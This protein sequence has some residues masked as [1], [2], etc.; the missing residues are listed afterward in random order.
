[1]HLKE[2]NNS[3]LLTVKEVASMCGVSPSHIYRLT[4]RGAIPKPVK[5]GS[6]SRYRREEINHWIASGC[7][8]SKV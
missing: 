1:M 4:D 6:A 8:V 7:P 5:L 3:R 2:E